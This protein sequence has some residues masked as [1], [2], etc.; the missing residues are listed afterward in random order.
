MD[1]Y[2]MRKARDCYRSCTRA[3]AAAEA[4]YDHVAVW[5][6]LDEISALRDDLPALGAFAGGTPLNA[7]FNIRAG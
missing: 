6:S 5:V 4:D 3:E 2:L 7:S 1:R